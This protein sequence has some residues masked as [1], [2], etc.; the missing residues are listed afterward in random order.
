MDWTLDAS[1]CQGSAFSKGRVL[2]G[3]DSGKFAR[4]WGLF[5]VVGVR[6]YED[7]NYRARFLARTP[8]RRQLAS[9]LKGQKG[10]RRLRIHYAC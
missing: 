8:R 9:I 2:H 1:E 4:V 3:G 6:F 10:C 5:D 7:F